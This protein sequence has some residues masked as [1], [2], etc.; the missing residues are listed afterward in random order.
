[1]YKTIIVHVDG[2]PRQAS[3]L[4]A[5]VA[6]ALQDGAHLVGCAATGV[7]MATY[8]I[9]N[10]SMSM[11]FSEQDFQGL[12][13]AIAAHLV[14]F[15]E[16][17]ARLGASSVEPRLAEDHIRYALLLQSR[18]ADLVVVSQDENGDSHLPGF[19]HGLPQFLALHGARPV[20]V[21]PSGFGDQ[22]LPGSAIVGWDGSMQ[23]IRAIG[24]ALPLLQR[25]PL[26]QLVLV[27]PEHQPELHGEEP[28]ADMALYLARHGV[29]VELLVEHTR[30]HAGDTLVALAHDNHAG[31]LV[32]GSYGHSRYREWALGGATR[33]L[34][35]RT[36]VPLL[37]AH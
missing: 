14:P 33:T 7:S 18:Y 29:K 3:R 2:G 1:M 20:L 26:V 5:A 6:L 25:A 37:T 21:V 13:E 31:L 36:P 17:A 16:Q 30:G 11:P 19:A 22:D 8:A 10:G 35:Q 23:A 4:R 34:L 24:A 28:G 27:N 32:A 12:R 15:E 9:L